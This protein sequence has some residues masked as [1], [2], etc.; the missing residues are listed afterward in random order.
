MLRVQICLLTPP[1]APP[2]HLLKQYEAASRG[3]EVLENENFE[4][5]QRLQAVENVSVAVPPLIA[6]GWRLLLK[7]AI[8]PCLVLIRICAS[9]GGCGGFG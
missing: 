4:L 1:S 8:S 5:R 7:F 9:P 6:K 3:A 2:P